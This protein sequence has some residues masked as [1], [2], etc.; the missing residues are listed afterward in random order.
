MKAPVVEQGKRRAGA[1]P[2]GGVLQTR[3]AC[4]RAAGP[5]GTCA[6]CRKKQK[7]GGHGPM[8]AAVPRPEWQILQ[9]EEAET[10]PAETPAEAPVAEGEGEG[11]EASGGGAAG[12]GGTCTPRGLSRADFLAEPGTSQTDFGLTAL[13]TSNVTFPQVQVSRVR[14]G[15][16]KVQPTTAALPA[17]P[18]VFTQAGMFVEGEVQAPGS[19]CE[20]RRFPN[21]WIITR[22]GAQKIQEGEQEHCADF[23]Y[24]FDT[25][26][27]VY[28]DAVNAEAQS[29]RRFVNQRAAERRLQRVTGVPPADW[30]SV[31]RCLALK[32]L[33]RDTMNWH[34]PRTRSDFPTFQNGCKVRTW[35]HGR[36]LPQ[37]GQ[38]ASSTIIKECDTQEQR[39]QAGES[40]RRARRRQR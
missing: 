37:V 38:H 20:G 28:R 10:P 8:I 15:S 5:A 21:N 2:S 1:P 26:L 34:L 36:S 30:A 7:P 19:E 9:R 32:S 35:V 39:Q 33:I 12:G 23:Q 29:S 22:D 25:S 24:A 27:A 13:D 3:C 18:S 16:F 17:I 6:S 14:G 11:A 31:F 40:H 4:G